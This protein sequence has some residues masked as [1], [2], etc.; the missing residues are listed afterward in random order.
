MKNTILCLLFLCICSFGNC[1]DLIK[2]YLIEN[3][4][5]Y[6]PNPTHKEE[7]EEIEGFYKEILAKRAEYKDSATATLDSLFSLFHKNSSGL[8]EDSFDSRRMRRRRCYILQAI[9]SVSDEFSYVTYLSMAEESLYSDR[10]V[11]NNSIICEIDDLLTEDYI[12]V[13]F[14]SLYLDS[15]FIQNKRMFSDKLERIS[16]YYSEN[17]SSLPSSSQKRIDSLLSELNRCSE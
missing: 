1:P 5:I 17:R 7:S 3:A 10:K 15:R 6:E 8:Y 9:A 11:K 14:L 12:N 4:D 16:E 13:Q 2:D